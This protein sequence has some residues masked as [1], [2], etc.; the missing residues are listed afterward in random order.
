MKLAR[1]GRSPDSSC[2]NGSARS[3]VFLMTINSRTMR[4][5]AMTISDNTFAGESE[6]SGARVRQRA[7]RERHTHSR[8]HAATHAHTYTLERGRTRARYASARMRACLRLPTPCRSRVP[9]ALC[10]CRAWDRHCLLLLVLLSPGHGRS[11]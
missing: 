8:T 4:D 7:S 6:L 3:D 2:N 1:P 10:V 5:C 9:T 11:R